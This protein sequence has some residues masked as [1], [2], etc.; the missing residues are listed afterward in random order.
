ME[1]SV[2]V[3]FVV[4]DISVQ[5]VRQIINA[6]GDGNIAAVMAEKYL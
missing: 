4:G 3:V 2:P 5:P 1:T 6:V